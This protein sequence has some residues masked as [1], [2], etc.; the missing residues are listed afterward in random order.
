MK[1][2]TILTPPDEYDFGGFDL[3]DRFKEFRKQR[4]SSKKPGGKNYK[5]K[6]IRTH[7]KTTKAS[8]T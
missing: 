8:K 3:T 2:C 4:M 6:T 5:V 1:T 7:K